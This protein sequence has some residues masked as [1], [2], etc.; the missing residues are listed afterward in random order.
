MPTMNDTAR[1][2][3]VAALAASTALS[4]PL[5]AMAQEQPTLRFAQATEE[6]PPAEPAPEAAA[7]EAAPA[8][9]PA[10]EAPPAEPAP[11]EAPAAEAAPEPA[12]PAPVEEPAAE[13]PAPALEPAAEPEAPAEAAPEPE[14][15]PPAEAPAAEAP[16]PEAPAA[17]EPAPAPAEPA[18]VA[19]A[20]APAVTDTAPTPP[21]A[22]ETAPAE[23]QPAGSDAPAPVAPAPDTA[24]AAAPPAATGEVPATPAP[25]ATTPDAVQPTPAVPGAVPPATAPAPDAEAPARGGERRARGGDAPRPVPADI[26]TAPV[27]QGAIDQ[28]DARVQTLATPVVE[29]PISAQRGERIERAPQAELPPEAKVVERVGNRDIISL[30]AAAVAGAAVGAAA[31]YFIRS[32]DDERLAVD[33]RDRYTE[34]LPRGRNRETIV[35]ANGAQVITITNRYG[36][37]V[38]RSRI[39]PDGRE[40]VLF[41][42]PYSEEDERPDY[43]SDAGED[44]PPLE[45]SIPR[46][47]YIVD[48]DEPDEE[49]YFDTIV[50]PPVETVERI[51]SVDEVR[52]SSRIRDKVRRIDLSTVNFD[53]GSASIP[54]AQVANLQ[55]LA[56]A[57]SRVIKDNPGETFLIEGHTDAVGSNVANL[58]LS[59]QRAE[60]VATALTEY[61]EVP[62]ENLVTQGYGEEDLKVN[63]QEANADNRRVTLRRITALVKPVTS[64]AK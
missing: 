17:A 53:F 47:R 56:D 20:E 12:A 60:A 24:P 62:P 23:T 51:Y 4:G 35:R 61:F 52:R 63:T 2:L 11:V 32:N 37:V 30:G 46:D 6:I 59:D 36:D 48:I 41:Y 21:A 28:S 9:E 10:A 42:D 26:Q 38:Q 14:A 25:P 22:T 19:P 39:T 43:Y 45:L 54:Q 49:L 5:L 8:E 50:A 16:A 3:T 18:P 7:P 55:A 44:L 33:S 13:A 64:A 29:Q 31:G 57:V 15:T 34:R 58:A 1:M 27:E 40:I